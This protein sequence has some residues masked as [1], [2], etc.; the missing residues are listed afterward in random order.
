MYDLQSVT[1]R[2]SLWHKYLPNVELFYAI[3]ANSDPHIIKQL[4]DSGSSFDCASKNEIELVIRLG[5]QPEKII[6]AN[7]IKNTDHIKYAKKVGVSLMTI[8]SSEEVE[9]IHKIFPEAQLLLRIAVQ[10]TDAP[11]PFGKKFG[12]AEKMWKPIMET[13]KKLK[14]SL[15]GVSFHVGSGGCSFDA[16]KKSLKETKVI[17]DV[18][19][20]MNLPDMDIID[21]GGGFSKNSRDKQN[22]FEI[23]APKV[24]NLL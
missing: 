12:A 11:N 19:K 1:D 20:N 6:F 23:V 24:H 10:E 17:F 9:K 2:V 7:A 18:A 15:R 16:Y 14:I 22:N 8:D 13:C 3:K 4:I 5:G 21:I